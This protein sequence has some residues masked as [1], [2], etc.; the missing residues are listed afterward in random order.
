MARTPVLLS[1]DEAANLLD[2]SPAYFSRLRRKEDTFIPIHRAIGSANYYK[3]SDVLALK[4]A[5]DKQSKARQHT[6]V[7]S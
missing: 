3:R 6:N 1:R 2:V 7:C 5:R 4:K